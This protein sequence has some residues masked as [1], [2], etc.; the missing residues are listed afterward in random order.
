ML[1][2]I[3]ND[4]GALAAVNWAIRTAPTAEQAAMGTSWATYGAAAQWQQNGGGQA[5]GEYAREVFLSGL[6]PALA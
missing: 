1:Y 6:Q 2:T 3:H 4:S 5:A